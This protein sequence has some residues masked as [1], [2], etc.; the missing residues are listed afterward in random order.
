LITSS[1]STEALL[2]IP[3]WIVLAYC[4]SD[5]RALVGAHR[6]AAGK[7]R[8]A[9]GIHLYGPANLGFWIPRVARRIIDTGKVLGG[10]AILENAY[11]RAAKN[12]ARRA[13]ADRWPGRTRAAARGEA[14]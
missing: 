7:Q 12:P 6:G 14:A 5:D 10:I 11:D 4:A 13:G 3:T 8:G 1:F 9:E 2:S